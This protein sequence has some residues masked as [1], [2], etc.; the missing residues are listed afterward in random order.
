MKKKFSALTRIVNHPLFETTVMLV[1]FV[2]L[3]LMMQDKYPQTKSEA[4]S[5][6]IGNFVCLVIF[7]LELLLK[8][9][10]LGVHGYF[11]NQWN[12]IDFVI[13][14]ISLVETG[15]APPSFLT[16]AI[17]NEAAG[18]GLSTLRTLRVFRVVKL[19]RFVPSLRILV[20]TMVAMVQHIFP[21]LLL[22]LIM[23]YI[24]TL[25]GMQLFANR[26]RFDPDTGYAVGFGDPT[27][28]I[29]TVDDGWD[30]FP[31]AALRTFVIL[32]GD[33]WS[34]E[35]Y[36]A[37]RSTGGLGVAYFVLWIIFGNL[38]LLNLFV[39]VMTESFEKEYLF[40]RALLEHEKVEKQM[41]K[42]GRLGHA[43]IVLE[44]MQ[45][46]KT[47]KALV[48]EEEDEAAAE[49]EVEKHAIDAVRGEAAKKRH[50]FM[51]HPSRRFTEQASFKHRPSMSVQANTGLSV[52]DALGMGMR[53]LR[54]A[55]HA[56][57]HAVYSLEHAAGIEQKAVKLQSSLHGRCTKLCRGLYES[58]TSS[59]LYTLLQDTVGSW[60][61]DH[62]ILVLIIVSTVTIAMDNPLADPSTTF[63]KTLGII[64]ITVSWC[65]IVEMV[66][67]LLAWGGRKYFGDGWNLLDFCLVLISILGMVGS[68]AGSISSL[69]SLRAMRALRPLKLI[70][71]N[72][73]MKA[74]I[75]ALLNS[76]P[77]CLKVVGT[78]I[79][80]LSILGLVGVSYFKGA[81]KHCAGPAW[82]V[83]PLDQQ[84]LITRPIAWAELS[85]EMRASHPGM[86][87]D[88]P[89]SHVVCEWAGA[90]W[91]ALVRQDFDDF[92][93]AMLVMFEMVTTE[94]WVEVMAVGINTVGIDMQP[95]P[96]AHP[97][98]A[99]YF[100]LII[101]LGSWFK[102][103]IFVGRL[104][105]LSC[106]CC[107]KLLALSCLCC[108]PCSRTHVYSRPTYYRVL[109]FCRCA[110]G[111][112]LRGETK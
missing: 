40:Q 1:V 9:L 111:A 26:F 65:F 112:I 11:R 102:M 82:D 81:W 41:G 79:L 3:I 57:E 35:M 70:R 59:K 91:K 110:G 60:Y 6:D 71:S 84:Q 75:T 89:N 8:I 99:A 98:Y 67:K 66:I 87:S 53:E 13:V 29:S 17:G 7:T 18:G 51:R 43:S 27:Y 33:D 92:Q 2:N 55:T 21:F 31:Q 44:Q 77:P 83:L 56:A 48:A 22:T 73:G 69:R 32:T 103:N 54:A 36:K 78:S 62:V 104:L 19:I 49:A 5:L 108:S 46:E 45:D 86:Y 20:G 94:G 34:E 76:L 10:G 74:V 95:R 63:V 101:M 93:S 88:P 30:T 105:A 80:I 68:G 47:R 52:D 96:D 61:F 58:W 15:I 109:S 85:E 12:M 42:V 16:G 37:R 64:D 90:E 106:L 24:F 39:A 107:C 72:P 97:E 25:M 14:V 4:R 100:V 50:D 23:I 28:N 38:I